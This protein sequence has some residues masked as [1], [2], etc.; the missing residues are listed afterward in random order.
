MNSAVSATPVYFAD[1]LPG[2]GKTRWAI[3]QMIGTLRSPS[4]GSVVLY[5]APTTEL[6]DEVYSKLLQ[7]GAANQTNLWM[8]ASQGKYRT[9][10]F[11]DLRVVDQILLVLDGG[12]LPGSSIPVRP[13]PEG[14]VI[15]ITHEAFLGLPHNFE[16]PLPP[17]LRQIKRR[18]SVK[19]IFDEARKCLLKEATFDLPREALGVLYDRY[20]CMTRR[21]DYGF[22]TLGLRQPL[23]K[24]AYSAIFES[25]PKKIQDA[26]AGLW[27]ILEVLQE[28]P[29]N[30]LY[31]KTT[32]ETNGDGSQRLTLQVMLVPQRLFHGWS[33][34]VLLSA[35]F[36]CSQMYHLLARLDEN[37]LPP[38]TRRGLDYNRL[39]WIS[40]V[41]VSHS[42][43]SKSREAEV[44]ARYASTT[45]TYISSGAPF[46][47]NQL[48]HG[49][50]V[51]SSFDDLAFNQDFQAWLAK[52]SSRRMTL[53][54]A[55]TMVGSGS[56]D[57]E[58]KE[59]MDRL[60]LYRGNKYKPLQF[61]AKAANALSR[62]WYQKLGLEPQPLPMLTNVGGRGNGRFFEP[63]FW[64]TEVLTV[65]P[66]DQVIAMPFGV[67]G[68]N[69]FKGHHTLAYLASVN[70]TPAAKSLFS[71]LCPDYN[72]DLDHTVDHAVQAAMR[73]SMR[74][75]ED[76]TTPLVI[77]TDQTLAVR[78]HQYLR[79]KP[80]LCPPNAICPRIPILSILSLPPGGNKAAHRAR[81][82]DDPDYART[83]RELA[84]TRVRKTLSKNSDRNRFVKQN[85]KYAGRI[86]TLR[87]Y[88]SKL[89]KRGQDSARQQAELTALLPKAKAERARLFAEYESQMIKKGS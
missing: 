80:N 1:V 17:G 55:C 71:V 27:K 47:K 57:G 51:E 13:C 37:G 58:L 16:S 26:S 45:I 29:S 11:S 89:K 82:K 78:M 2:T 18:S 86:G 22:E 75:T 62:A 5:V 7:S 6:L 24:R 48:M 70:P 54:Q 65:V 59:I 35:F 9:E 36:K 69:K 68:L 87:S 3:N 67:H 19:V 15:L 30:E 41:D 60:P 72:P 34:V 25:Y 39:P 76:R 79:G 21:L 40:L 20:L 81:M 43:V 28:T 14:S 63:K 53:R 85:S 52:S 50:L 84:A 56:V 10:A 38:L 23:H 73:I 49:V 61:Y 4:S 44:L 31:V 46:S 12:T 64:E 77:V 33:K 8:V 74:N 83:H 32:G 42:V 66:P 88:I